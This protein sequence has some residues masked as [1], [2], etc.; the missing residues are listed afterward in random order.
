M[1]QSPADLTAL[2]DLTPAQAQALDSGHLLVDTAPGDGVNHNGTNELIDG[3]LRLAWSDPADPSQWHTT[4][5]PALAIGPD[6]IE[7]G[8]SSGRVGA[9]ITPQ[10]AARHQLAVGAWSLRVIDPT[11]PITPDLEQRL[12]DRLGDPDW[13]LDVERGY[14]PMPQ[15]GVWAMTTG[16]GLVAVIGA[17]MATILATAEQRPFHATLQAVGAS[18][19]LSRRLATLQAALLAALGSLVGF[20]I[21]LP[22]GIP[23]ALASTDKGTAGPTLVLP[24]VVCLAYLAAVPVLAAIVAAISTPARPG[25]ERRPR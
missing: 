7:R 4:D 2:F 8:S 14:E 18:P 16:L 24:W 9:L 11:G 13:P 17:A 12:N 20:G 21:G 6:V 3:H 1:Q 22:A 10:A 25:I 23:L 15:P 5:L 19:R